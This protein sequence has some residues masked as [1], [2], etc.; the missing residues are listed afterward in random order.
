M[1]KQHKVWHSPAQ[2]TQEKLKE[3]IT[4]RKCGS[5]FPFSLQLKEYQST[6]CKANILKILYLNFARGLV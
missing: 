1:Q 2:A 5:W 4:N 6:C 3:P